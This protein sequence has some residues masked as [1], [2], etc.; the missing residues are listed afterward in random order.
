MAVAFLYSYAAFFEVRFDGYGAPACEHGGQSGF[1][2]Y[3]TFD[4]FAGFE[5]FAVVALHPRVRGQRFLEVAV[6]FVDELLDGFAN[7]DDP[8]P[9]RGD[10]HQ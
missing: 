9:V 1:E 4:V 6:V 5:A 3:Q 8:G 2:V 10:E 7:F